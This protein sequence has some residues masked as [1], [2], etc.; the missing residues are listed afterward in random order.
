MDG[1]S[2]CYSLQGPQKGVVKWRLA[3]PAD[4]EAQGL[5]WVQEVPEHRLV[6]EGP[7]GLESP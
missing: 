1:V 5:L 6:L 3:L 2:T 4:L 7:G